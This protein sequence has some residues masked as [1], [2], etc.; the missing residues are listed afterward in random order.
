M[1]RGVTEFIRMILCHEIKKS[2][3]YK[4][5]VLFIIIIIIII[6]GDV[7]QSGESRCNQDFHNYNKSIVFA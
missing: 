2:K 3:A 1:K 6:D 7:K 5:K 4:S